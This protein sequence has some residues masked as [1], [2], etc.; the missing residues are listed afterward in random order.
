MRWW[1]IFNYKPNI[2]GGWA[3]T[4]VWRHG[5]GH[6]GGGSGGSG[7]GDGGGAGGGD[8]GDDGGGDERGTGSGGDRRQ[9]ATAVCVVCVMKSGA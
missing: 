4:A 1:Y 3:A 2:E 9:M 7:S 6:R 5:D 8:G